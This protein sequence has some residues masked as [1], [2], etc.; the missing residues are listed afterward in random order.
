MA[1]FILLVSLLKKEQ[2]FWKGIQSYVVKNV[3]LEYFPFK[4]IDDIYWYT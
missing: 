1:L 4:I 3:S 2:V